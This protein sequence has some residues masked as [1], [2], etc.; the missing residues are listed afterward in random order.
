MV[1]GQ[2]TL[3]GTINVNS[4]G[5]YSAGQTSLSYGTIDING[6]TVLAGTLSLGGGGCVNLVRG[7][8]SYIGDLT[9]GPGGLLTSDSY[10]DLTVAPMQSITLSGMTIVSP[11]TESTLSGGTLSTGNLSSR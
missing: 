3:K 4:G 2:S 1:A 8:L 5:L 10:G 9:V 6:G 11:W 7:A